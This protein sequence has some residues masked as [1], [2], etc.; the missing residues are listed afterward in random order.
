MNN[1]LRAGRGMAVGQ[2]RVR[3][4]I[5]NRERLLLPL[6]RY[7]RSKFG[8]QRSDAV[9]VLLANSHKLSRYKI[10]TEA[11][12]QDL[13]SRPIDKNRGMTS[14]FCIDLSVP[15]RSNRGDVLCGLRSPS[16]IS[17]WPLACIIIFCVLFSGLLVSPVL[18]QEAKGLKKPNALQIGDKIP[19]ELW[20]MPLQV[21]S[22]PDQ[23]KTMTLN[24]YRG[25]LI[26]LDFWATWCGG[27]IAAFPKLDTLQQKYAKD[28]TFLSVSTESKERVSVFIKARGAQT[29]NLTFISEGKDIDDYFKY[30]TLP[31]YVW[32]DSQGVI[33]S[34]SESLQVNAFN[35]DEALKGIFNFRTKTDVIVEYDF[36]RS[37]LQNVGNDEKGPVSYSSTLM[38]YQPGLPLIQDIREDSLIGRKITYLNS[39]LFALYTRAYSTAGHYFWEINTRLE[40]KDADKL[41]K[42]GIPGQRYADWLAAGNGY[43]YEQIVH[44]EDRD[45]CFKYMQDDLDRMIPQYQAVVEPREILCYILK[46]IDEKKLLASAE[47]D[48]ALRAAYGTKEKTFNGTNILIEKLVEEINQYGKMGINLYNETGRND[49][50]TISIP[51]PTGD[52]TE[53]NQYLA[54]YGLAISLEKR[55]KPFLI[56]K[57]R[58][59]L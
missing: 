50:L 31:H 57:D 18:G 36:D 22:N 51:K 37:L 55:T 42:R 40:V 30:G 2:S 15:L 9:G 24:D 27:C 29:P 28:V 12:Y 32:I 13:S 10:G 17:Y 47:K 45:S 49:R 19:D 20:H 52:L 23:I 4:K 46:L 39:N 44:Y 41:I 58:L 59:T 6:Q 35:I 43:C 54:K 34:S 16:A 26:I 25:K 48:S 1:F 11:S 7:S 38:P 5:Q 8:T 33:R 3:L 56:I 14:L 53:V 21:V